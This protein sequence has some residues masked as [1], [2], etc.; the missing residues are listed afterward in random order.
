VGVDDWT[1]ASGF[2]TSFR[3]LDREFLKPNVE[4]VESIL[5][6]AP[7]ES[8]RL[9]QHPDVQR[10]LGAGY[11][12]DVDRLAA[13]VLYDRRSEVERIEGQVSFVRRLAQG[14]IDILCTELERRD[15][16]GERGDLGELIRRLPDVFGGL[17][18][19]GSRDVPDIEPDGTYSVELD[20]IAGS[21]L[22]LALPEHDNHEIDAIV[23]QLENFERRLST[24]R[25]ELHESIE[26][27]QIEIARRYQ[28]SASA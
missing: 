9:M 6:S 27:L 25:S 16:G 8:R 19:P 21:D 5:A 12:G 4:D 17:S 22:F 1:V 15:L 11:L 26:R 23:V 13:D 20:D 10:V 2:V 28:S 24:V 7:F 14:R 18:V 3:I